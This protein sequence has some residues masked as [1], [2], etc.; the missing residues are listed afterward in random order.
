MRLLL[1]LSVSN[2]RV[3]S[4]GAPTAYQRRKTNA[5]KSHGGQLVLTEL[6]A[7]EGKL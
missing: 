5:D 1:K 7:E 4:L 6:S 3:E 2:S